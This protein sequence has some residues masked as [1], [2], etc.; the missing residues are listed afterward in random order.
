MATGKTETSA[1]WPGQ[2]KPD[3][4]SGIFTPDRQG[5]AR[6]RMNGKDR[7]RPKTLG[8]ARFEVFLKNSGF[9]MTQGKIRE[10]TAKKNIVPIK[11]H[12]QTAV[13][14]LQ[15]IHKLLLR[16]SRLPVPDT[17][18]HRMPDSTGIITGKLR[19]RSGRQSG[20]TENLAPGPSVMPLRFLISEYRY[21]NIR[22]IPAFPCIVLPCRKRSTFPIH[23]P[24]CLPVPLIFAGPSP[25]F[26]QNL[27]RENILAAQ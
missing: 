4:F 10:K 25:Y 3:C 16:P 19:Q 14:Y 27:S 7:K 18:L 9:R 8:N 15:T 20:A 24:V 26:P 1:F 17:I 11:T 2:E 12:D 22:P 13:K 23:E 6:N 21:R 5:S